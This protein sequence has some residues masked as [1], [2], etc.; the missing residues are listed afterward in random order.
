MGELL[1]KINVEKRQ[2]MQGMM[3]NEKKMYSAL[4]E[5]KGYANPPVVLVRVLVS[6]F[7]ILRVE[8]F[9]AHLGEDLKGFPDSPSP[10]LW[11][12]TQGNIQLSQRHPNNLLRLLSQATKAQ[13]MEDMKVDALQLYIDAAHHIM[14]PVERDAVHRASS[15]AVRLLD[16]INIGIKQANIE[17]ELFRQTDDIFTEST[18]TMKQVAVKA[19]VTTYLQKEISSD[20]SKKSL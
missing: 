14:E 2:L 15:I 9:E 11:K 10:K 13:V 16:W 19:G 1:T 20:D 8:G 7:V 3:K 17:M 5:I 4:Q 12:F 6:L 18:T